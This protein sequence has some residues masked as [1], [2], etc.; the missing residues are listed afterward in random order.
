M[1]IF[2]FI[3]FYKTNNSIYHVFDIFSTQLSHLFDTNTA[4]DAK[5]LERLAG[6]S[7]LTKNRCLIHIRYSISNKNAQKWT[8]KKKMNI[9]KKKNSTGKPCTG[10]LYAGRCKE[11]HME[12]VEWYMRRYKQKAKRLPKN[13]PIK[14][15]RKNKWF[16]NGKPN[17]E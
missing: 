8:T 11:T 5:Q 4:F 16:D 1:P 12:R 2:F 10:H 3:L 15:F 14:L 13:L 17:G 6:H 9:E 7:R